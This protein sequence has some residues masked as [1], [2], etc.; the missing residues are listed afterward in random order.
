M[1]DLTMS[2]FARPD[3]LRPDFVTP[4]GPVAPSRAQRL[5]ARLR[6]AP[7]S[8]RIR[9]LARA[10]TLTLPWF[11]VAAQADELTIRPLLDARLR[12]EHVEQD[13]LD[14]DADAITVRVRSGAEAS[15]GPFSVLV[16]GESTLAIDGHYNSGTNGRTALPMVPDPQNIELNRAQLQFRAAPGLVATVGRQRIILDDA[17]FVGNVGWRQNEQT[18]DAVRLQASPVAGLKIDA[19]YVWSVRTIFGIDGK[20]P[21]PQGISGDTFLGTVS[22]ETPIGTLGA[23]AYLVDETNRA[24]RENSSQTYG[25]RLA[26]K[27]PITP[28]VKLRYTL[29]Y[30]TQSDYGANPNRYQADYYL[31][32]GDVLVGRWSLG[33]GYEVLGADDGR[34]RT[35]F[36]TPLATI[37]M[38]Q[39]WADK[40]MVTPPDGIAD[41]YARV[42]FTHAGLGPFTGIRLAAIYHDFS[43][44]RTGASYGTEWDLLAEAKVRDIK[45]LAKYASY[46]ANGFATD[47]RKFWVSMEYQ[48]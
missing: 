18:F 46:S 33:G 37:H 43:A 32:E 24:L 7:R 36:Q 19:S 44:E 21:R 38:F 41:A 10:T 28:Q 11:P 2:D 40:F 9:A 25:A 22:Y 12:Y 6:R 47:T 48:F 1:P 26:G 23:F 39:G 17:R 4:S 29:S 45:L 8:R 15:T 13:G 27:V 16:E 35:S 5:R 14:E 20:G 30:A 34:A 42:G 31:A 3:F